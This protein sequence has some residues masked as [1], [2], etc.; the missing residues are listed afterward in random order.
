MHGHSF[1]YVLNNESNS[2]KIDHI[3][4]FPGFMNKW[5]TASFTS[6]PRSLSDHRP[7]ILTT[8]DVDFGP[9]PF[10][11]FSS[12]SLK[13]GFDQVVQN[14]LS[15]GIFFGKPGQ[16]LNSKLK[17]LKPDI[18]RWIREIST[19]ENQETQSLQDQL[20]S[21]DQI[22]D[23]R[24][25]TD[26]EQALWIDTGKLQTFEK[27]KTMD[28]KQKSRAKWIEDSDENS[29]FFHG[30]INSRIAKNRLCGLEINGN[31]SSHIALIPKKA[32]V[33]EL[34]DVRPITLIGCIKK[35]ISKTLANK[36]KG[37]LS[38][39]IS[40]N[41]SV[42]LSDRNILD[43]PLMLDEI[44]SWL[45][46]NKREAFC[47]KIDFEKAFDIVNWDFL[48]SIMEQMAFPS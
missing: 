29:A 44:I 22:I 48:L 17:K 15:T 2:S 8:S 43:G 18:K 41:Q 14:S 24:D 12:W 7:L 4:M 32:D 42:F 36:L 46:K 28:L 11:L 6:L 5:P 23:H 16:I 26:T 21:L 47:L 31:C 38:Q 39:V 19:Q 9:P 1:T 35:T 30:Y 34:K 33:R 45:R 37:K 27:A 3:L 13:P 40:Q 25:F 20:E 10:R